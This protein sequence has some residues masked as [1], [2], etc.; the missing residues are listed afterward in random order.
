L[1]RKKSFYKYKSIRIS[2][3]GLEWGALVRGR[4]A[5]REDLAEV[6]SPSSG[7]WIRHSTYES[8]STRR[9]ITNSEVQIAFW[10]TWLHQFDRLEPPVWPVRSDLPSSGANRKKEIKK[11]ESRGEGATCLSIQLGVWFF[12]SGP[13]LVTEHFHL[14]FRRCCFSL[15][16]LQYLFKF[17]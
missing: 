9:D 16:I 17:L 13:P 7:L 14:Y 1:S 8:W 10:A 6:M 3:F 11:C 2:R 15:T 12:L 4:F 5:W